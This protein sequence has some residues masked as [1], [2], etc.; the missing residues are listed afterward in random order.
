MPVH[1][2]PDYDREK[3]KNEW[4][5]VSQLQTP[6]INLLRRVNDL[7]DLVPIGRERDTYKEFVRCATD[8]QTCMRDGTM[9]LSIGDFCGFDS[10]IT[11]LKEKPAGHRVRWELHSKEY[12]GENF[13]L[14]LTCNAFNFHFEG[15]LRH[16]RDYEKYHYELQYFLLYQL[17]NF[18]HKNDDSSYKIIAMNLYVILVGTFRMKKR[19]S[20]AIS[21]T[22][23][24]IQRAIFEDHRS[25]E[26]VA[27]M[28]NNLGVYL[29]VKG[30]FKSA[31]LVYAEAGE[32]LY[33]VGHHQASVLLTNSGHS[34]QRNAGDNNGQINANDIYEAERYYTMAL[35]SVLFI[36]DH[37]KYRSEAFGVLTDI[38]CLYRYFYHLFPGQGLLVLQELLQEAGIALPICDKIMTRAGVLSDL[39]LDLHN[40]G[41]DRMDCVIQSIIEASVCP[42]DMRE[43]IV[44]CR[45]P[46]TSNSLVLEP[47][48]N[49]Y[50]HDDGLTDARISLS[51]HVHVTKRP[52]TACG[53]FID[54]SKLL[55]C[56]W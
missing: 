37:K 54:D 16:N 34:W 5:I 47:S 23:P 33:K 29:E 1:I 41:K 28:C 46:E 25:V 3:A 9:I 43:A 51:G 35:H 17:M 55:E 30:Q 49:Y 2:V 8:V 12:I 7:I 48:R 15:S 42:Q 4:D 53:V 31:A 20:A 32:H 21:I 52:C 24:A 26:V 18:L 56:K 13:Q 27:K 39:R 40:V 11:G 6:P 38:C 44:N 50:T 22:I 19:Y 45:D 10:D 36:H 14:Y